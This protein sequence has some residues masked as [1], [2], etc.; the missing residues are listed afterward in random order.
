MKLCL[1]AS[2]VFIASL[3]QL[4][5]SVPVFLGTLLAKGSC[6]C[7]VANAMHTVQTPN[8]NYAAA[9]GLMLTVTLFMFKTG[10]SKSCS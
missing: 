5:Q 7:E 9:L 3:S 10:H 6:V 8:S 1:L 2:A 4:P